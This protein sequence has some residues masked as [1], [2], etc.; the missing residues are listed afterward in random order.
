MFTRIL[1]IVAAVSVLASCTHSNIIKPDVVKAQK[2]YAVTLEPKKI[3]QVWQLKVNSKAQGWQKG[4]KGN[5]YV[6]FEQGES[7][8]TFFHLKNE[9]LDAGCTTG[10]DSAEWVITG[11]NISTDGNPTTLK[12]TFGGNQPSGLLKSFPGVNLANGQLVKRALNDARPFLAVYNANGQN[13][14]E[15]GEPR[16]VYYEVEV[17]PCMG[18]VDQALKTD[19]AWGNGGRR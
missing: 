15:D 11:L 5:G 18:Q 2:I 6:G 8:W 19:P 3:Q 13:P 16:L 14:R 1:I 10:G 12:G 4:S 7:G 9:D 17:S